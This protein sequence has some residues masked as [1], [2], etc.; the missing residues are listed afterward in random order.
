MK[1]VDIWNQRFGMCNQKR[2][3]N[4]KVEWIGGVEM[5]EGK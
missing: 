3:T 5:E 2:E 1:H 4:G